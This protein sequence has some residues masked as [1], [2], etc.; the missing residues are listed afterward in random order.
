MYLN[1][2]QH[3]NRQPQPRCFSR[4]ANFISDSA[5]GGQARRVHGCPC[6]A[7]RE[8]ARQLRGGVPPLPRGAAQLL[9]S[10]RTEL[11]CAAGKHAARHSAALPAGQ[12]AEPRPGTSFVVGRRCHFLLLARR[13]GSCPERYRSARRM[14]SPPAKRWV[15][16]A[17]AQWGSVPAPHREWIPSTLTRVQKP[18]P[19]K[20]RET[21]SPNS[22]MQSDSACIPPRGSFH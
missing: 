7:Q 22:I 19:K 10:P 16:G 18:P 4:S 21:S 6:P 12:R 11:P 1:S 17:T 15:L 5:G 9:R 20:E 3:R 14:K 2:G 8:R 13:S